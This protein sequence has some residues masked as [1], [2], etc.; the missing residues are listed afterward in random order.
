[1]SAEKGTFS[2]ISIAPRRV[3]KLGYPLAGG[4]QFSRYA[5]N[6]VNNKRMV[7]HVIRFVFLPHIIVFFKNIFEKLAR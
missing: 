1:M 7:I 6:S 4:S 3:K 5:E 2:K